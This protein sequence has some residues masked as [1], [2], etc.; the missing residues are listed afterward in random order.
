MF[1]VGQQST[2]HAALFE[3]AGL[4]QRLAYTSPDGRPWRVFG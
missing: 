3:A 4:E 1:T 2:H